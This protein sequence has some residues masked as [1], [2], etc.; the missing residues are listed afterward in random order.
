V[1]SKVVIPSLGA[2]GGDVTLGEWLVK[3]GDFVKAGTPLFSLTTDKAEVEVEAFRDGYVREILVEPGS[4]VSLGT[5]VAIIA[6]SME[7]VPLGRGDAK[8]SSLANP[9]QEA[10]PVREGGADEYTVRKQLL[11]SPLAR[12]VAR[13]RGIDLA[14]VKGSPVSGR[15]HQ[16]DVLAAMDGEQLSAAYEQGPFGASGSIRRTPVSSMRRA[17]AERTVRSKSEAPHF[18]VTMVIDMTGAL[19][20]LRTTREMSQED[21][22]SA[23]SVTDLAIY[24]AALA[25]RRVPQINASFHERE[26]LV[27]EDINIG[28]V[29]GLSEGVIIPVIRQADHKSLASI[30][31]ATRQLREKAAG[32]GLS[33]ADLAGG[34]LTISNLGMFGVDSFIP[35][36]NLPEA[37]ILAL[38]A[39]REQPAVWNGQIVPRMLMTVT[40]AADHRLIDGIAAAQFLNEFKQVLENLPRLG[41]RTSQEAIG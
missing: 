17:I 6:D 32:G 9:S 40:L 7:E 13:D 16:R 24:A 11:V 31:A 27:F 3:S 10:D 14:K 36:I 1:I 38:A 12:R 29:I 20:F 8:P 21:G 41:L 35:V 2:T 5:E 18:Y 15:I 34:T 30:A 19:D 39:A 22:R 28:L 26:I 4:M 23:P 33:S 37:A 25:L